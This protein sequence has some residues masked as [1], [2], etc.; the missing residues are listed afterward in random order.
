MADFKAGE[1]YALRARTSGR[2]IFFWIEN[3]RTG[4]PAS[5][6]VAGTVAHFNRPYPLP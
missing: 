1:E 2:V 3:A 5:D 4:R 6:E